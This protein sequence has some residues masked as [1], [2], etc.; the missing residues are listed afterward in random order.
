MKKRSADE[1]LDIRSPHRGPKVVIKRRISGEAAA[2]GVTKQQAYHL[3]ETQTGFFVDRQRKPKPSSAKNKAH[4]ASVKSWE[5][6]KEWKSASVTVDKKG[7]VSIEMGD[8]KIS[9]K[10]ASSSSSSLASGMSKARMYAIEYVYVDHY[11]TAPEDKWGDF[12]DFG[13]RLPTII[14]KHLMIPRGS[15]ASVVS[16]MRAI[17]EA[18]DAGAVYDP[19]AK[20]KKGRGA[21]VKIDEGSPQAQ[22]VYRSMTSGLSLGN[23]LVVVN[24]WRRVQLADEGPISYGALQRFVAQSRVLVVDKR[25]F[26][27]SGNDDEESG[28]ALARFAFEK[29]LLR[30]FAKAE[31]I[32]AGGATYVEADDGPKEQADLERPIYVKGGVASFD[33]VWPVPAHPPPTPLPPTSPLPKNVPHPTF[34]S[35][36][37]PVQI[38]CG[39][40]QARVPRLH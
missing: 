8:Q 32:L 3:P 2:L 23:T 22:T 14:M 39:W 12:D 9:E 19:S 36:P 31:R 10:S 20:I 28:W 6:Y 26:R 11:G 30:Q 33:Q 38:G 29:Q 21:P 35:A 13:A 27:K 18:H 16:A 7:V 25:E 17:Y 37:P 40:R 24:Q 34:C 5:T 4:A 1:V 15:Y